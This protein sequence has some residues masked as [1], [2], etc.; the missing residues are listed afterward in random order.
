MKTYLGIDLGS[1]TIG[2]SISSSGIIAESYD[3]LYFSSNKYD[4]AVEK[5]ISVVK[6]EH[7]N[8]IVLG[9]PKHMNNDIGIRGKISEDVKLKIE[10]K[11]DGEVVLWDERLSTKSALNA[12]ILGNQSRKK[13]KKKKD[14]MAAVVI[15]QN[16]LDYKGA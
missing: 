8:V 6:L 4:E 2:L 1:K 3:T 7:I 12:M 15:L 9:Y 13:Q 16:Y 5:I 10:E 14:E 11:F